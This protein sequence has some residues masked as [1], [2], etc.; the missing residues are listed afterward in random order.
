MKYALIGFALLAA[1]PAWAQVPAGQAPA[2]QPAAQAASSPKYSIQTST[3][4]QLLDNPATKAIFEKDFP[5]V[6]HHPQLS[7]GLGLTLPEVVQYLP[8]VVTP[9]KLAAMDVELKTIP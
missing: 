5:E 2:D 4:G 9:E 7:E 3:L 6:A 8:D 1:M